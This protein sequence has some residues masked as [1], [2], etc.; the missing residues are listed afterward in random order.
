M[1]VLY[2]HQH[3]T[4]PKG[5]GGIRS[6][7]NAQALIARGH[8]VTMVCGSNARGATGLD[9]P[10]EKGRREGEVDGIR[11]IEFDLGYS[12]ND[13]FLKR[14]LT[15]LRFA[16]RSIW[17]ALTGKYDLLFATTTPL[18]VALPGIAARWLRGKPF[19]FEVRDLWPELP[20]AMAVI[21]NP[22]I[23]WAMGVLEWLAYRSAHRLVALAPGIA[24]GI[25]KR[26]VPAERVA[27]VPNGS[28]VE[29]FDAAASKRPAD[30]SESDLVAIFA[31]AHGLA[32]GLGAVLDAAA[33]L[34]RRGRDDIRI[35]LI[36]TGATKAALEERAEREQL[37]NVLFRPPVATQ[38]VASLLKGADIG[39]QTLANV[40]AFYFGT[41]PN[42][43]FD[44]VAAGLPVLN[45]Y[46]G[47]LAE[48]IETHDAGLT[49]AP[50]DAA[51][52]ADALEAA[53]NDR[54]TLKRKGRNARALAESE[55]D[56]SAL[57]QR[58]VDHVT[59]ED[60]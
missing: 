27:I 34:K 42:K 26:G 43:F 23:L 35:V 25:E 39:L 4:T 55:F 28:D 60:A 38:E 15:F 14:S 17:L 37:D 30:L 54:E 12:N 41:S 36:G 49:V 8:E 52:F 22:V 33:E 57:A 58:W 7:R 47:W 1:H 16:W 24:R 40:E 45:N 3:F 21:N 44:Y 13:G 51:A 19:V 53:A 9:G 46:P 11:V 10:F 20:R 31:G 6:Y 56:R 2:F 50:D 48:M 5:A 32:N 59:K 29:T 18:T